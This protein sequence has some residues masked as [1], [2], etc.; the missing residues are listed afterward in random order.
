MRELLLVCAWRTGE[1]CGVRL[2]F[3]LVF[4]QRIIARDRWDREALIEPASAFD[5]VVDSD[6]VA[7]LA[8]CITPEHR[9]F[10]IIT[11]TF[12]FHLVAKTYEI[13]LD[14]AAPETPSR[15]PIVPERSTG[16]GPGWALTRAPSEQVVPVE[17]PLGTLH[18]RDAIY[19]WEASLSLSPAH[20]VL[21][22]EIGGHAFRPNQRRGVYLGYRVR[23]VDV[24]LIDVTELD[25]SH[26]E[27]LPSSVS[28]FDEVIASPWA[29]MFAREGAPKLRF[30]LLRA[31]DDVFRIL[32]QDMEL[33]LLEETT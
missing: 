31:Y 12:V 7:A 32:C 11:D 6:W 9:H 27:D 8:E 21:E 5:V 10:S 20:L 17:T 29:E 14:D 15:R 16:R 25:A 23:F 28:Q 3:T 24:V 30:F 2:R 1:R 13:E 18:C 22:G 26:H 19:L 33:S 4:A